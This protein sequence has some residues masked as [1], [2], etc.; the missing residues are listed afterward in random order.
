MSTVPDTIALTLRKCAR[1]DKGKRGLTISD[2]ADVSG[3]NPKE[4]QA[5]LAEHGWTSETI[6]SGI[7]IF[8][9][10]D[11]VLKELGFEE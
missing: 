3:I 11:T 9:A 1:R 10:P 5:Y 7:T 2:L 8:W 6:G 4:C